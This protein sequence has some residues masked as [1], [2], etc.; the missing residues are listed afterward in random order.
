MQ[1]VTESV[2]K[3]TTVIELITQFSK[4]VMR[5]MYFWHLDNDYSSHTA[6]LD[7]HWLKTRWDPLMQKCRELCDHWFCLSPVGYQAIMATDVD[8]LLIEP[9]ET[10]LGEILIKIQNKI[11]QQNAFESDFC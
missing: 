2:V 9:T 8:W 6:W 11:F 5:G 4:W 10:S 1:P 3:V 7:T